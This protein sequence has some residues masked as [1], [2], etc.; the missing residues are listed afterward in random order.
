V[1]DGKAQEGGKLGW[2]LVDDGGTETRM[3][4]RKEEDRKRCEM[5]GK[6]ILAQKE[7]KKCSESKREGGLKRA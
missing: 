4:L 6:G 7:M 3:L 2:Q 5:V 1:R